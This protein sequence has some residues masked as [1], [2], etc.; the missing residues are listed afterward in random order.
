MD[1]FFEILRRKTHIFCDAKETANVLELKRIIE[2]ILK[3]PIKDQILKKQVEDGGWVLLDDRKTLAES[4]FSQSNAKAQAPASIGLIVTTE[5]D[6]LT[7]EP[8]SVPPPVPD[9]MRQET[10]SSGD[11]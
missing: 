9:A 3:V 11:Q 5:E 1:L 10:P 8:L 4:G 7:I 6:E 2:G